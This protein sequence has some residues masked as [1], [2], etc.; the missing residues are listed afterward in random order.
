[1]S[2]S[3]DIIK[4][5]APY[6][7]NAR[8]G[9]TYVFSSPARDVGW[10][11]SAA[12]TPLGSTFYNNSSSTTYFMSYVIESRLSPIRR[13]HRF[14]QS[15]TESGTPVP[16]LYQSEAS[17]PRFTS[18]DL[19]PY[20]EAHPSQAPPPST[21]QPL[22]RLF[23]SP[24]PE[25]IAN[26][27]L[28]YSYD[29]VGSS[30]GN[31]RD[32]S[33]QSNTSTFLNSDIHE[34][35][36]P[37]RY[38]SSPISPPRHTTNDCP[39]KPK[40]PMLPPTSPP[41]FSI[42]P[43]S[44]AHTYTKLGAKHPAGPFNPFPKRA[45]QASSPSQCYPSAE[46]LEDDP[47]LV[48][49]T[50]PRLVEDM[51]DY[52]SGSLNARDFIGSKPREEDLRVNVS[53]LSNRA[54]IPRGRA[55]A[56]GGRAV[57]TKISTPKSKAESCSGRA[58]G[59]GSSQSTT[60]PLSL[61]ALF[62][63]SSIET[64]LQPQP[65]EA[66]VLSRASSDKRPETPSIPTADT[67]PTI[68]PM[69][70]TNPMTTARTLFPTP[71]LN[72]SFDTPSTASIVPTPAH[73]FLFP[74]PDI[75]DSPFIVRPIRG[76][77]RMMR[78]RWTP[79]RTIPSP[80]I[81]RDLIGSGKLAEFAS[82]HQ[83]GPEIRSSA[84]KWSDI[85]SKTDKDQEVGENPS[86]VLTFKSGS[87]ENAEP[88]QEDLGLSTFSPPAR[89]LSGKVEGSLRVVSRLEDRGKTSIEIQPMANI[90]D[91]AKEN[92]SKR[93]REEGDKM[94]IAPKRVRVGKSNAPAAT[95]M[96]SIDTFHGGVGFGR[97]TRS[98]SRAVAALL[99]LASC[100]NSREEQVAEASENPPNESPRAN[101]KIQH[102]N[103][104]PK[105]QLRISRPLR[106][107]PRQSQRAIKHNVH[108]Q[109][110]SQ[111]GALPDG[112]QS[113]NTA[114]ISPPRNVAAKMESRKAQSHEAGTKDESQETNHVPAKHQIPAD[115]L[116]RPDPSLVYSSDGGFIRRNFPKNLPIHERYLKW[117]R[118][119]PVS[120]YFAEEDP[121]RKFVLGD[122]AG[123]GKVV[124]PI[125]SLVSNPATHFNLYSPRFVRGSGSRKLGV[126]P[127][128][129]EPVWRG[130]AGRV[131]LL[132]TKVFLNTIITCNTITVLY[133][134]RHLSLGANSQTGLSPKTGLPF[135]PPITFRQKAHLPS[136]TKTRERD[137]I[138][139]GQCHVCKKWVPVESVVPKDVKVPEM[140][141]WK[142][143]AAC[144]GTSQ[145][146]GDENPYIEDVVYLKLRQYEALAENDGFCSEDR[147]LES[148]SESKFGKSLISRTKGAVDSAE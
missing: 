46:P 72:P 89:V 93:V 6:M 103:A 37:L 92:I 14:P 10:S 99:S 30:G 118:R 66:P 25:S 78:S 50:N 13:T 112:V 94:P 57:M 82:E 35:S 124:M 115:L 138:E 47:F 116:P 55:G 98:Q 128:C 19:A 88:L 20:K 122:Q 8:V 11:P 130:G 44:P 29:E 104:H 96:D 90:V 45:R 120:A 132:N 102:T 101:T 68:S 54:L 79:R 39:I 144:H 127:I 15:A 36:F 59:I 95:R 43:S 75:V 31:G 106:Q 109:P 28:E 145:L 100:R 2:N 60:F 7:E 148:E 87:H 86:E 1:M 51:R 70:H 76:W 74:S 62:S 16:L 22:R 38:S 105:S 69:D 18:A 73:T 126:C 131:L 83:H 121:A 67:H 49:I 117:Y 21:P 91:P 42:Y 71:S 56:L 58:L 23:L 137:T 81:E 129:V 48:S 32:L 40:F 12:N 119:F 139:E 24:F 61:S 147:E 133:F 3:E 85:S 97:A 125:M 52:K 110:P 111:A 108:G 5:P 64:D 9:D 65:N 134:F 34:T 4:A 27:Y 33:G 135:S 26:D 142:H 114:L 146:T 41:R 107:T 84:A 63:S 113:S 17:K 140:Y 77:G 123:S 141:W 136:R 53:N 143:A 80:M